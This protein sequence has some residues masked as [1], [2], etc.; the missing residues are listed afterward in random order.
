MINKADVLA[1]LGTALSEEKQGRYEAAFIKEC[2][3]AMDAKVKSGELPEDASTLDPMWLAEHTERWGRVPFV[4]SRFNF[5]WPEL[6]TGKFAGYQLW[7]KLYES[8]QK[9]YEVRPE[10]AQQLLL[11]FRF[12]PVKFMVLSKNDVSS[13][14]GHICFQVIIN[15]TIQFF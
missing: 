14:V 5:S 1:S 10:E 2:L 11:V 7:D 3:K 4:C 9:D 8:I 15:C 6:L 12:D 13:D